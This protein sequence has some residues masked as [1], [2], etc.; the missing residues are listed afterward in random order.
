MKQEKKAKVIMVMGTTSNAGKTLLTAGLCRVFRQ[1]GYKVAPFKA[2]NMSL[3]S[4]ITAEGLEMARGQVI[5]AEAAGIL[6]S[7]R[8]NPVLLKP[9]NE[10]GSQ[11]IVNGQVIGNMSAYEYGQQKKDLIPLVAASYQALASEYDII[12]IEGAGS[13][14]EI[15]LRQDDIANMGMAEIADAPVILVGDIDRGGVFASLYGT[16]TL[17]E[18]DEQARIKGTVINKFRGDPEILR[19]GLEML[20]KLLDKPVLGV[21][22]YLKLDLDDEDSLSDRFERSAQEGLAEIA[23]IRLPRIA[24]FTDFNALSRIRSVNLRY[25]ETAAELGRPDLIILPGTKN[26]MADLGWLRQNGLETAILRHAAAG[27][28]VMGICGGFQMMGQLLEDPEGVEQGGRM[29]GLGLLKTR[30][31]FSKEKTRTQVE[32]RFENPQGIFAALQGVPLKGY[33]IHMGQTCFESE[34]G[35]SRE[36]PACLTGGK[37]QTGQEIHE[38]LACGNLCGT[39]IHGIFDHEASAAGLVNALLQAKGL[40]ACAEAADWEAHKA[41]QYDLLASALRDSLDMKRIYQI[42]EGSSLST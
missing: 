30:T 40:E 41:S 18:P 12:V 9:V 24:N 14:A 31:V 27:G 39:Y 5:Q 42:L 21:V 2:Q 22:P 4:F 17:L 11:V 35:Q 10:T 38:G 6:P 7:V 1:D 32:G 16:V 15:N 20:E 26:T 13:P 36:M 37:D 29:A 8:M 19:P 34:T 25:V 28:A 3:N 33:E 23:V